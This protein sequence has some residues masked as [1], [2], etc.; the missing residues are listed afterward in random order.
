M[1]KQDILENRA[2]TIFLGIGSNLGNRK[3][4]IE[5]A[6]FLLYQNSIEIILISSFYETPSWP[7]PTKPKFINIVLKIKSFYT[8]KELLKICKKIEHQL[9][10][11]KGLKNDPRVCDIDIL[12][13][14][15][16]VFKIAKKITLPHISMHQRNF[17]LFPLYEIQK[18]WFHPIKKKDIKLLISSL[19][20]KDITSIKLI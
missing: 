4:N 17:V 9:G 14:N 7:D 10:R 12:D 1:K 19:P 20:R 6:K 2:K 16:E 11:R 18:D 3:K 13:F 5:K 15:K 8:P